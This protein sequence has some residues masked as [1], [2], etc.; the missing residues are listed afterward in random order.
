MYQ[1]T[2]K[3][4]AIEDRTY[5]ANGPG[6]LRNIVWGVARAQGK[7]VTDDSAMIAEVGDLRSRCDIEGVGL[8][9]VHEITVKVEDADPDMYECEGGHDNEDSAIL[10]GPVRCDG[11]CRPRRRFHKGALLSLAE[12]LD[13]AELE[14]EGGCAACGLEAGQMCAGCGKCNCERH[15]NCTRPAPRP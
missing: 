11:A 13:D 9:D 15:D 10:G 2:I 5:I 4:P 7:P 3:H 8:L 12:A 14:S 1:V 6:E